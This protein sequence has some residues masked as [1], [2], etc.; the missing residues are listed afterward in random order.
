LLLNEAV[1]QSA[2]AR[3]NEVNQ[4]D[5]EEVRGGNPARRFFTAPGGPLQQLLYH[6]GWLRQWL[7]AAVGAAVSPTG[8]GGTYSFYVRPGDHLAL[9]RDILTCDLAVISCLLDEGG[10]GP[11]L[12]LYPERRRE[13]L[14]EV[15]RTPRLGAVELDLREGQTLA[16]LGGLVP[17]EVLALQAGR[18]R[19]VSILCFR[20]EEA[21]ST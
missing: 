10:R 12:R 9:H 4:S 19:I 7:A 15:R 1:G 18:R 13:K 3:R 5:G 2:L 17:H 11:A 8:T 6:A 21:A 14:S 20:A 16:F